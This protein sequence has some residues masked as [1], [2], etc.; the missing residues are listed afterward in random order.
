MVLTQISA[1]YTEQGTTPSLFH[2]FKLSQGV[3]NHPLKNYGNAICSF[4]WMCQST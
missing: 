4:V 3:W 2:N 1:F